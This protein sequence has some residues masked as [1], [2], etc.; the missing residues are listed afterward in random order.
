V[1]EQSRTYRQAR[2]K[3]SPSPGKCEGRVKSGKNAS[4][5]PES[6]SQLLAAR[7]REQIEASDR[8]DQI[9]VGGTEKDIQNLP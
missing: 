9:P 5:K 4:W 2:K 7:A 6:E 8:G 3:E 1:S